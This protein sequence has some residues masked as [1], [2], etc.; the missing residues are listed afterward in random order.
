MRRRPPAL[1][2]LA[3]VF[4]LLAALP[5]LAA[6]PS[7]APG[8]TKDNQ[9]A[10]EAPITLTGTIDVARDADGRDTYSMTT[11]GKTYTLEAGPPWFFG[12]SH[13]LKPYAGKSVTIVGEVAEGSTEVDV[14]SVNGTAL[15]APGKPPWAGGWRRVGS[16]HPGWSQ[17]KVD[18]MKARFGDCFPP[19]QCKDKSAR[20]ADEPEES[21]AP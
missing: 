16:I 9:K 11:G 13:P 6:K 1:L 21:A 14:Q 20:G 10:N 2:V 4:A 7:Q 5:A 19:G 3:L 15:R 12:D 8:Q 18:R 17:D